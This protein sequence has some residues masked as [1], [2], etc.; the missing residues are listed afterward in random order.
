MD[1]ATLARL[2]ISCSLAGLLLLYVM[3]EFVRTPEKRIADMVQLNDGERI[4]V[5]GFIT[6]IEKLDSRYGIEVSEL[7]SV[8][9]TAFTDSKLDDRL[10]QGV[11]IE[12][13][14]S[15][16]E[17]KGNKEL[18]ADKLIVS[19]HDFCEKK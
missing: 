1:D 4:T 11:F 18:L 14:G 9:I 16:R 6:N 2:A 5:R 13:E 8:K 15:V 17:Y 19:P 7:K 10:K 3:T 12:A